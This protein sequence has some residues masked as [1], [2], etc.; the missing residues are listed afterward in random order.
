MVIL[1]TVCSSN[2][3]KIEPY[4][5][6]ESKTDFV[7]MILFRWKTLTPLQ[8]LYC[9]VYLDCSVN[10]TEIHWSRKW[11]LFPQPK[12]VRIYFYMKGYTL[13][14]T[15]KSVKRCL[16]STLLLSSVNIGLVFSGIKS[17]HCKGYFVKYK[18]LYCKVIKGSKLTNVIY[19]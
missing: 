10:K 11:K 18:I 2:K 16:Q 7:V 4:A 8:V 3:Q 15:A 12:G 5:F 17:R 19:F 1:V 9:C 14:K 6:K 13:R